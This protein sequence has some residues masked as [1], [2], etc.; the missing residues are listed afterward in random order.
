MFRWL[1]FLLLAFAA[2]RFC[3]GVWCG[4]HGRPFDD[5]NG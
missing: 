2:Y 5:G 1:I 4:Y 3:R